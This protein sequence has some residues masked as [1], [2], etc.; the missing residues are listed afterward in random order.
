MNAKESKTWERLTQG[1][2]DDIRRD[3]KEVEGKETEGMK[4]ETEQHNLTKTGLNAYQTRE[5][6]I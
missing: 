5:G 1:Q 4:G 2:V 3:Q 6:A